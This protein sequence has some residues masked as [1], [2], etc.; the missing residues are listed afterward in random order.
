MPAA[1]EPIPPLEEALA[2][3]TVAMQGMLGSQQ[4]FMRAA[5][6]ADPNIG[7]SLATP[8]LPSEVLEAQQIDNTVDDK[9][10]NG[11]PAAHRDLRPAMPHDYV[12]RPWRQ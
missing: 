5:A 10:R 8:L 6:V 7:L 3:L 9:H 12:F 1:A 11:L 4:Q 2:Q